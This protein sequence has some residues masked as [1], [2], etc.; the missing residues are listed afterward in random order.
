MTPARPHSTRP[1]CFNP[2]ARRWRGSVAAAARESVIDA[3]FFLAEHWEPEDRIFLLGAGR[4]A[5]CARALARMLGT[6]GMMADRADH[7]VEYA[8][9]A[10]ALPGQRRTTQDWKQIHQLACAAGGPRRCRRSGALPRALGHRESAWDASALRRRLAGQRRLGPARGGHRRRI[11]AVRRMPNR[12]G[13][14]TRSRKSGSAAH[15]AMSSAGR[16]RTGRWPTSRSTGC[17]TA[18]SRRARSSATKAMPRTPA[19]TDR[20]RT[21]RR[22]PVAALPQGARGRTR[23]CQR[24]GVRA[25]ASRLLAQAAVA[26]RLVRSGLGRTRRAT[27]GTRHDAR[28]QGRSRTPANSPRSRRRSKRTDTST[29]FEI[30]KIPL[31]SVC[32]SK[33]AGYGQ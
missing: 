1:G 29:R 27:A 14:T 13:M 24:R 7:F 2:A 28:R 6:V 12:T 23:A 31:R 5:Y 25:R 33:V 15:T 18:W 21:R 16:T 9:A 19:P 26:H 22:C 20:R 17:S 8:L 32:R 3:Y 30:A 10:Y 11:W 4:G